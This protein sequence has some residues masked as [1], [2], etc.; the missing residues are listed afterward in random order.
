VLNIIKLFFNLIN[1]ISHFSLSAVLQKMPFGCWH[2]FK[3]LVVAFHT[4]LFGSD[5][6]EEEYI[7]K[8]VNRIIPLSERRR[9]RKAP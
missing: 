3:N 1:Q 2:N 6:Q 5:E 4:L 7:I 8:E 9:I